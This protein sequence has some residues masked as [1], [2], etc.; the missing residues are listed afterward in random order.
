MGS[1]VPDGLHPI[2]QDKT[3]KCCCRE[4]HALIRPVFDSSDRRFI[5]VHQHLFSGFSGVSVVTLLPGPRQ[6]LSGSINVRGRGRSPLP[7]SRH[8]CNRGLQ[9]N[10]GNKSD[11]VCVLTLPDTYRPHIS[12]NETEHTQITPR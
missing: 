4:I 8:K 2:R 9:P 7:L 6:S 11:K 3:E 12:S 10:H 5:S 1:D